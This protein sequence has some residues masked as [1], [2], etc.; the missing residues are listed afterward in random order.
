MPPVQR[1]QVSRLPS[2]RWRLRYYDQAG[3]RHNAGTFKTRS[4]AYAH[5][6]RVIEPR[7]RGE[8]DPVPELSLSELVDLYLERHAAVV[9]S[10]TIA[11]LRERL[12]Y[13]TRDYGDVPLADLERMAGELASWQAKL[14]ERS[15]YGIVQA[16][17]QTLAA[18]VRWDYMSRNPARLAGKNPEPAPREVRAYTMAEL[19][20]IAAELSTQYRPLPAF[21]AATGLRPEEWIVLERRDLDRATRIASVR[22][23]L[24]DGEVVE[25]AK[26]SKSRRQVP[27]STRALAALDD[28]PAQLRTPLL[29][30]SPTGELLD[31]DNFRRREWS[32]AIEASGSRRPPASTTCARPSPRTRSRA[33][34]PCS[35]SPA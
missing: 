24:S 16:L 1:G 23:T 11:T 4:A 2:G 10:R 25:L 30:P 3:K 35:S 5:F 31:L 28:V 32:P 6:D 34:S 8:P 9:R 7:L 33:A 15:R 22:R 17:R 12:A 21:V 29:F 26:T 19:S 27:L 20:A 18:A 14:P 13:A